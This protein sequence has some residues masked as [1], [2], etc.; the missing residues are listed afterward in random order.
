D[1]H[2]SLMGRPPRR[3]AAP[4]QASSRHGG[5]GVPAAAAPER[6]SRVCRGEQD[7]APPTRLPGRGAAAKT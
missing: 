4:D 7:D 6:W 1:A 5:L 2:G 3:A